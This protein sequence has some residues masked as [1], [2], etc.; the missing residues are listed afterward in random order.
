M[1]HSETGTRRVD[2]RSFL[3]TAAALTATSTLPDVVE[4]QAAAPPAPSPTRAPAVQTRG[5]GG[6]SA[7][8]IERLRATMNAYTA[9]GDVPGIVWALSRRAELH[10]G[11][12]GVQ[13]TDTAAAMRRDSI[14]RIASVSKVITGAATMMLAEEGKVRLDEPVDGLL[15][16]LANRRVLKRIDAQLDDTVPANRP[17]TVRDLLTF[18]MGIGLLLAPPNAYPIQ[19]AMQQQKV[20]VSPFLSAAESPDAWIKGL[21]SLPLVYQPG[22]KWLYHTGADALGVL[23]ARAAGQPLETFLRERFFGPLGMKDT[24]FSVSAS[25]LVRLTTAYWANPATSKVEVFD[26]GK[27][28]RWSRPPGF[29]AAGGGLVSTLDDLLSFGRMLLENG[30]HAGRRFLSRLSI[31]AMATDQLTPEQQRETFL[32]GSRGWG[33]GVAVVTKRDD[34]SAVPGRFGWDGGY[35]TSL[36]VDPKE[37]LVGVLL[38]QKV[39]TS[40][41]PPPSVHLDFWNMAYAAL[42]D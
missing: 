23:I 37:R 10:T 11:V 1:T 32:G 26:D 39:W 22:E 31:E 27:S 2:R 3:A 4:A 33:L 20:D 16:E 7:A 17:I 40:A 36:W 9:R 41:N 30:T 38:T 28:S 6:F 34:I 19:R 35:G 25:K 15:P 21:G 12:H 13:A 29:P 18:R 14:F 8:R 42:E 5:P 24:S